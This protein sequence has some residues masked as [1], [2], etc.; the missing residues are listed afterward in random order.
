MVV[1]VK[2]IVSWII[3]WLL[4]V[5]NIDEKNWFVTW[6]CFFQRQ[7]WPNS[8]NTSVSEKAFEYLN[9][10]AIE[11]DQRSRCR[12][13][14]LII[15]LTLKMKQNKLFGVWLLW[16]NTSP[17][18]PRWLQMFGSTTKVLVLKTL[19]KYWKNSFYC[20]KRLTS[21]LAINRVLAISLA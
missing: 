15:F 19:S 9:L 10:D 4:T 16:K 17:L 12:K 8:C 20:S 18:N 3:F 14:A 5:L 21:W 11:V 7:R 2:S 1:G 13:N 6:R